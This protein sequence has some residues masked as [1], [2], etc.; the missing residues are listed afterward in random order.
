MRKN[1]DAS[2]V[3]VLSKNYMMM[4]TAMIIHTV[5]EHRYQT[6]DHEIPFM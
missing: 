1:T 4:V 5:H 3:G 2:F 6:C